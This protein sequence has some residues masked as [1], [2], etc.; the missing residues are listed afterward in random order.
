LSDFFVPLQTISGYY[1]RD[2]ANPTIPS[3]IWPNGIA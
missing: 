1:W 2:D 3:H